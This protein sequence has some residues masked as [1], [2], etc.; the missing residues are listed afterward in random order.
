MVLGFFSRG[1][2]NFLNFFQTW[3]QTKNSYEGKKSHQDI[4]GAFFYINKYS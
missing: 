3:D 1:I 4:L 2:K